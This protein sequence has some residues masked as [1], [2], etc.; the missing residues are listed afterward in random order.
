MNIVPKRK[1]LY[2][3]IAIL[4]VVSMLN[5]Y[6]LRNSGNGSKAIRDGQLLPTG[7][8]AVYGNELKLSFDQVSASNQQEANAVISKMGSYDTNIQLNQQQMQRYINILYNMNGGISCEYC[9][10]AQA[11]IFKNGRLACNC[12]H[13]AAMR[14]ITKYL[15]KY[16][17][18]Q[19]SDEQIL[20]EVAKWKARFFPQ[21]YLKKAKALQQNGIP[22]T[23]INLGSNEYRRLSPA[24]Y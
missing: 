6:A 21:Q 5:T 14:G 23:Y 12:A 7:V 8:P 16:H 18:D 20:T 13:S 19:M 24:G 11:V 1:T 22:V 3:A 2:A 15:L 10:G 17:G 4:L 9:C